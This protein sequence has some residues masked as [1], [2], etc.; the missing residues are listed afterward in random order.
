MIHCKKNGIVFYNTFVI[1][2]MC[3]YNYECR[4]K[5]HQIKSI[6][7]ATSRD[8]PG[9]TKKRDFSSQPLSTMIVL[10]SLHVIL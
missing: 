3:T 7:K 5:S 9:R 10:G 1:K 4:R 6:K 2:K 8:D